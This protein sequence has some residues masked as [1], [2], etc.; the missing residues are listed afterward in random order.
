MLPPRPLSGYGRGGAW[1]ADE[2]GSQDGRYR[3]R[4]SP[5]QAEG[6]ALR[7]P[8]ASRRG[9]GGGRSLPDLRHGEGPSAPPRAGANGGCRR[10]RAAPERRGRR[11][12]GTDRGP[13][14]RRDELLP[15]VGPRA[16]RDRR[17][18]PGRRLRPRRARLEQ[19]LRARAQPLRA[20]RASSRPKSSQRSEASP[21]TSRASTALRISKPAW[22]SCS[23]V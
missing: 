18:R 6:M 13:G 12:G 23:R 21:P 16:A 3:K 2:K 11:A 4:G 14:C 7:G 5:A 20:Q 22:T 10:A 1:Y 8:R 19:R 17:V 15:P 9:S